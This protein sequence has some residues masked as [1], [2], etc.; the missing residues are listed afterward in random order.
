MI[1]AG[2]TNKALSSVV[3]A[4][5]KEVSEFK[6]KT[7]ATK[8]KKKKVWSPAMQDG[9][10]RFPTARLWGHKL[11]Y[12]GCLATVKHTSAILNTGRFPQ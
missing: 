1:S 4:V 11:S 7:T 9:R 12:S 8:K 10:A 6:T 3:Q 5:W 2:K